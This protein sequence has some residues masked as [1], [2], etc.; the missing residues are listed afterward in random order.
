MWN[1]NAIILPLSRLK[2][3]LILTYSWTYQD[4]DY[5]LSWTY[6]DLLELPLTLILTSSRCKPRL[7]LSLS[8]PFPFFLPLSSGRFYNFLEN[9]TSW[10]F[11]IFTIF[12]KNGKFWNFQSLRIFGK[13]ENLEISNFYIFPNFTIFL[14]T[15]F[16]RE[17]L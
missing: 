3:R 17:K 15:K 5:P 9:L 12:R 8:R 10:K 1:E 14:W 11:A 7:I 2:P 13:I 4:L 16:E 6:L